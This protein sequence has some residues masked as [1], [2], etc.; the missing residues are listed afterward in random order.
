MRH[1]LLL[2]SIGSPLREDD[3]VAKEVLILVQDKLSPSLRKI[4]FFKFEHQVD[5]VQTT[6][7]K[8]YAK[9]IFVDVE[10]R[11][12]NRPVVIRQ[13]RPSIKHLSFSSHIGS[14]PVL[15][16]I[17]AS[18]YGKA[19]ECY[20]AGVDGKN[21]ALSENISTEGKKNVILAAEAIIDLINQFFPVG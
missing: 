3:A 20:L 1:E 21:F 5:L 9:V 2:I 8:D 14:I 12:D 13:I 4:V 17:T 19:P 18:I 11:K 10:N 7:I 6:L 16:S 15:L